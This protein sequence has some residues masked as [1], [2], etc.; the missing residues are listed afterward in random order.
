M[1]MPTT[2]RPTLRAAWTAAFRD[3]GLRRAMCA[4]CG[5][6][7]PSLFGLSAFF[8]WLEGRPGYV[9]PDP[10]LDA[11]GPADVSV[12]IFTIL[13][14][15]ILVTLVR[16]LCEPGRVVRGLHAYAV[17]LL[18]RMGAMALVTLDPPPGFVPLAD[19][20]TQLFYPGT[21]PFEKD[22]FFSGHTAT[23]WLMALIATTRAGRL[24]SGFA[25]LA[26]GVL[27]VVQHAHYTIDVIAAPPFAWLAWRLSTVTMRGCGSGA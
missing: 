24:W 25:T 2:P 11:L 23:L 17:L 8:A 19:A 14:A 16:S 5:A 27:V 6:L 26:V 15:T 9:L 4:A 22:L 13:Y 7:I 20:F 12:P 21:E 3:A 18:L 10:L 1:P